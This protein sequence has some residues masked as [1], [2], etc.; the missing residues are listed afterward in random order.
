M[1]NIGRPDNLFVILSSISYLISSFFIFRIN[2]TISLALG[3]TTL[4]ASLHHLFPNNNYVRVVDWTSAI[5]LITFIFIFAK[6]TNQITPLFLST[7]LVLFSIWLVSFVAFINNA[8]ILYN[9][10]HATW[11]ILSALFI[12]FLVIKFF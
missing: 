4:F 10:A 2:L 5:M 3:A 1:G 8:F 9:F 11:H 12:Y 6:N 7:V